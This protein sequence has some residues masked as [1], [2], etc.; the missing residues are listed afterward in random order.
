MLVERRA[1]E[2][3]QLGAMI[4]EF[5]GMLRVGNDSATC[6]DHDSGQRD[7]HDDAD[8]QWTMSEDEL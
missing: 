7:V 4:Q 1:E 5:R 8:R 6:D 3:T 2:E